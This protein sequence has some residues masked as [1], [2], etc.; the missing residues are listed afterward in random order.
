M[1][2]TLI[3]GAGLIGCLTAR[4]LADR[5]D[6]VVLLDKRPHREAVASVL[7]ADSR[8]ALIEADVTDFDSLRALA[9]QHQVKSVVHTAAL[10]STAIRRT[11]LAG[12]QVN[13]MGCA[14]LLELARVRALRRVVL[15]SSATVAYPAFPAHDAAREPSGIA[16]DFALR[17]LTHR[18][19]SIYAATKCFN[20]QLALLYRDLYGVSAVALRYGAVIGAWDGPQTS[21]PG[22]LLSRLIG[23]GQRGHPALIDDPLL[24]WRGGEEFVDAR[25]CATANVAA[26]DAAAPAQGVYNVGSGEASR[27]DDVVTAVRALHPRLQ[28]QLTVEPSGG[29]AGFPHLRPAPSDISAAARELGWAPRH[30]L[31]DSV[32]HFAPWFADPTDS[33][34]MAS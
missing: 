18:P 25:D 12:V 9:E 29:F 3:T 31:A 26:L 28:V 6:S 16:E 2:T 19:T 1:T 10:L 27:F 22:R 30:Q 24:A 11:P 13:V 4:L 34:A 17:F 5:G 23:A 33:S 21:V 7:G 20:E 14:N 15:A 32:R 8:V